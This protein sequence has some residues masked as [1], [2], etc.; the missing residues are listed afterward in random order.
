MADTFTPNLKLRKQETGQNSN[1][2]GTL[3][4]TTFE[5]IDNAIAGIV[6]IDMSGG[7][8]KTPTLGE[9]VSAAGR[10]NT[11]VL[12]G[13][14]TSTSVNLNLPNVPHDYTIR[15]KADSG[16][17]I[18][19]GGG[20]TGLSVSPGYFGRIHS[21]GN[22]V[23]ELTTESSVIYANIDAV[24]AALGASI[25][26]LA[27]TMSTS[28]A[29]LDRDNDFQG[30]EITGYTV[31][32]IEGATNYTP[33]SA[34]SGHTVVFFVSAGGTSV[35]HKLKINKEL[36]LGFNLTVL[37][38]S[39]NPTSAGIVTVSAGASVS[40]I[41]TSAHAALNNYGSGAVVQVVRQEGANSHAWVFFQGETQA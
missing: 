41:N 34:D 3:A 38:L 8:S 26:V 32:T 2:W 6:S 21:T 39:R 4:N 15:N 24:S 18:I 14:I 7:E 10:F 37:N 23:Y 22:D 35:N 33:T 25:S 17:K 11:L 29:R 5:N 36:P 12:T 9:G 19:P 28:V 40:L 13:T 16:V 20:G 31:S 27:Q 30:N 1:T